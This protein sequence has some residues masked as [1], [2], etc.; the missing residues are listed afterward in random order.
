[1]ID[2]WIRCDSF[3]H[4]KQ[5]SICQREKYLHL[6]STYH[7][8]KAYLEVLG[9]LFVCELF[10]FFFYSYWIEYKKLE[11]NFLRN[12]IEFIRNCH[13]IFITMY[14]KS[15]KCN[16]HHNTNHNC[17]IFLNY[18]KQ[19]ILKFET[20]FNIFFIIYGLCLLLIDLYYICYLVIVRDISF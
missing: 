16:F 14:N 20:N 2:V 15:C 10:L 6:H 12:I 13:I 18:V 9:Y 19:L 11:M 5:Q 4:T 7:N 17:Y 3:N 1:M 8:W